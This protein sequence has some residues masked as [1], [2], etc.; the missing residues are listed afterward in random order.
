MGA[1]GRLNGG[2]QTLDPLQFVSHGRE[3]VLDGGGTGL[4]ATARLQGE[5][6]RPCKSG[7]GLGPTHKAHH[8]RGPS[9]GAVYL[10]Q[11]R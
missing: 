10:I 5:E 4:A 6:T 8:V 1:K 3:E 11:Q 2:H 9:K 7:A